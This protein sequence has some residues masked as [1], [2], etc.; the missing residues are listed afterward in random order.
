MNFAMKSLRNLIFLAVTLFSFQL[1]AQQHTTISGAMSKEI[2]PI[3]TVQ[4]DNLG[5]LIIKVSPTSSQND[6]DFYVGNWSV[7]NRKLK[8]SLN[9]CKEWLEFDTKVIMHKVLN[10][11]GNVDNIYATFD[12]KPFEGMSL[13]FFNPQT[14]LWTI[15]WT[16]TNTLAIDTPTIGSFDKDFGHFFCKDS[17]G[18]RGVLI[19]YRW[20][21]RDQENPVWSQAFSADNGETWEWNWYMHFKRDK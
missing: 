13:R 6:F 21:I 9:N 12:G 11:H 5:N 14:K 4:F 7:K 20:D 1:K 16:D 17:I 15:H 2:I 3:P 10:G 18:G 19:V 8:T